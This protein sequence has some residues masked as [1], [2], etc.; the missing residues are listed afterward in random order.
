MAVPTWPLWLGVIFIT[1]AQLTLENAA[2]SSPPRKGEAIALDAVPFSCRGEGRRAPQGGQRS[3]IAPL[4]GAMP[5][6]RRTP[7]FP[8]RGGSGS[9]GPQQRQSARADFGLQGIPRGLTLR[10]WSLSRPPNGHCALM[11]EIAGT[12]PARV[13]LLLRVAGFWMVCLCSRNNPPLLVGCPDP[14]RHATTVGKARFGEDGKVCPVRLF[15]DFSRSKRVRYTLR[16]C[17]TL[18]LY[19]GKSAAAP[20]E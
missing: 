15:G 8:L 19:P 9:F 17:L 1:G 3:S 14:P 12:S 20:K 11:V 13:S 16:W 7:S 2:N 6:S 4:T 18:E 5:C 10:L